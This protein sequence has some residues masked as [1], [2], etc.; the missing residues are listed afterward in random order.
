MSHQSSV[1]GE[2]DSEPETFIHNITNKLGNIFSSDSSE[3]DVSETDDNDEAF[4][5]SLNDPVFMT[6]KG[7]IHAGMSGM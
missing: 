7:L 3:A 1:Q 4:D 5:P 6:S 2:S